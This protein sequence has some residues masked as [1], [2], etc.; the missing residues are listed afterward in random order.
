M[1]AVNSSPSPA[2]R[3]P[4]RSKFVDK[5]LKG[6]GDAVR[7]TG[8]VVGTAY[9]LPHLALDPLVKGLGVTG[10]K[11]EMAGKFGTAAM[12]DGSAIGLAAFALA[13][14]TGL[15]PRGSLRTFSRSLGH[16]RGTDRANYQ[17]R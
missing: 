2:P 15:P 12:N 1:Q 9:R 5:A 17:S 11:A 16:Y 8:G 4:L 10:Y 13:T 7:L 14:M 3:C 6:F